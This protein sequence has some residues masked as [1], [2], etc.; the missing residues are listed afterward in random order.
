MPVDFVNAV[1]EALIEARSRKNK[2]NAKKAKA[3]KSAVE[4]CERSHTA[5]NGSRIKAAKGL[6]DDFGLETLCCRHDIP[7][8]VC[9]IDT[10][11]EQQ[12]Y[13]V[14]LLL[15][16]LMHLPDTTTVMNL[17]DIGCVLDKTVTSVSAPP[18]DRTPS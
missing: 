6:H 3:P 13:A 9:N 16:L 8:F 18:G 15:W 10:P 2:P 12:K 4:Q 5:A 11:G 14:S 17:Y 7:I 1:G